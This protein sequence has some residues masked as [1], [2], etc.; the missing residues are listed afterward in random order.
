MQSALRITF[1][2]ADDSPALEER[3]RELAMRLDKSHHRITACRIVIEGPA[4]H[5]NGGQYCVKVE[6][7]L[8][9]GEIHASSS[10]S[11]RP[12]HADPYLALHDAFDSAK[13]Q[14]NYFAGEGL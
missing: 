8:P 3:A 11:H 9:H 12:E 2:H 13:K 7:S 14:L 4:N 1:R 6:L 10:H 5:R